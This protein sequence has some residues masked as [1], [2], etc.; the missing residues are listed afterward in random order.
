MLVGFLFF[1]WFFVGALSFHWFFGVGRIVVW[2]GV[3]RAW[4]RPRNPS[5]DL[6]GQRDRRCGSRVV[7]SLEAKFDGRK[8]FIL[9]GHEV[10]DSPHLDSPRLT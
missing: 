4:H 8:V 10:L 6:V 9:T 7:F 2:V 1:I 3:R 5:L